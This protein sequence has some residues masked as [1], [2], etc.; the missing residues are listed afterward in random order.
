MCVS[1]A[2]LWPEAGLSTTRGGMVSV[3]AAHPICLMAFVSKVQKTQRCQTNSSC[4]GGF[5][6]NSK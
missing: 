6:P 4:W 5:K 2:A 3:Q 1:S